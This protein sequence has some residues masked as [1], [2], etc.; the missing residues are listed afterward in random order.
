M[1]FG[2]RVRQLR[3]EKKMTQA[4]LAKSLGISART[5][6][7]IE[8][9]KYYPKNEEI[10]EKIANYFN[11]TA[12]YLFGLSNLKNDNEANELTDCLESLNEKGQKSLME[13]AKLLKLKYKK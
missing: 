12:D 8:T 5:V 4:Q 6:S 3:I 2:S 11:V 13:Y 10:I 1:K 9:G 7:F